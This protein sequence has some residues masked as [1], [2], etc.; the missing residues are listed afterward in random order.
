MLQFVYGP[1][2]GRCIGGRR[3]CDRGVGGV[4]LTVGGAA[5]AHGCSLCA[6]PV[7]SH[8]GAAGA[9]RREPSGVGLGGFVM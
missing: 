7:A 6:A 5:I 4:G 1:G 9:D 2:H 3:G 8:D